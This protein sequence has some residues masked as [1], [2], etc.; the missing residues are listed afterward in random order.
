MD[1]RKRHIVSGLRLATA[2]G[3]VVGACMFLAACADKGDDGKKPAGA[4]KK[5]A[6]KKDDGKAVRTVG[7]TK[8]PYKVD[9]TKL[10][11]YALAYHKELGEVAKTGK[12]PEGKMPHSAAESASGKGYKVKK[13]YG[14][15]PNAPAMTRMP[16]PGAMPMKQ[17]GSV[18]H[19]SKGAGG[20]FGRGLADAAKVGVTAGGMQDIGMA[21]RY[22]GEGKVPASEMVTVEGLLSEHD[23]PLDGEATGAGELYGSASVAWTRRY[24]RKTPEAMVQIGF[25]LDMELAKFK[26]KPLNLA[27]VMDVSGSMNGPRIAA[28]K[29]ALVKLVDQLGEKDRLAVVLF[30]HTAWVLVDSQVV[31]D[32]K[33]LKDKISTIRAGGSTNIAAGMDLGYKLVA[34]NLGEKDKSPRVFLL[35]DARPNV[36]TTSAYG[37]TPMMEGAAALGIGVTAFGVGI[38]FG[39]NLAYKIFQVRGANYFYLENA[40]KISKVF[41]E[42]F[43]FMVTPVAYD[44]TIE[45]TPAKGATVGDVLGVPD[46]KKESGKASIKIPSLFLSK[47][48]GG[49]TTMVAI[50][51]AP[52]GSSE[53]QI[54]ANLELAFVTVNGEQITQKLVARLPG[55]VDATGKTPY[56]SQP[57]AKKAVLLADAAVALKAACRGQIYPVRHDIAWAPMARKGCKPMAFPEGVRRVGRV[58]QLNKKTAADAAGGL[59]KFADWFASQ[60]GDVPGAEKE[61]QLIEKLESTLRKTAGLDAKEPRKVAGTI[62]LAAAP[63]V[64]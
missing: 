6:L 27:V 36:G 53:K 18:R 38:D 32:R 15:A 41:D 13:R 42:E 59:G 58:M 31:K 8:K 44:V 29:Q 28:T 61:L 12:L 51:L 2:A 43:D 1:T 40:A 63:E 50:K 30:N 9:T 5:G 48:G 46:F 35:T 19:G 47:R 54:I 4:G 60:I 52:D 11:K 37:F 25:G 49:G 16:K 3:L 34:A 21:R 39:Q 22:I 10:S 55:K 45:L 7:I 57:G 62:K 26:R 24:G 56:Y 20:G 23:I 33:A 64:F 14:G 17:M